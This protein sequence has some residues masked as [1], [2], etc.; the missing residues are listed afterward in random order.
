MK[1]LITSLVVAA[2]M[3]API[4][5]DSDSESGGG[6]GG[7]TPGADKAAPPDSDKDG[8]T[9][10]EDDIQKL[11]GPGGEADPDAALK[12]DGGGN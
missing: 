8:A 2:L 6:T 5:C 1:K 11:Q 3:A 4:G 9:R 7:V 10:S 12:A